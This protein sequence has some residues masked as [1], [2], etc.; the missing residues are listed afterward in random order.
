MPTISRINLLIFKC[1]PF[2]EEFFFFW[3]QYTLQLLYKNMLGAFKVY[4]M[5]SS[6]AKMCLQAS[7]FYWKSQ[8]LVI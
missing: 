1:P 5:F 4:P 6:K 8:F 7:K 3:V 2:M